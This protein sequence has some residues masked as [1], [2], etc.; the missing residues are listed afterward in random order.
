MSD[1]ERLENS[2]A[3]TLCKLER[4]FP[5]TFFDIM[6]HLSIH[7]ATEAK[8]AGPVQYIW[9]YPFERYL[10]TLKSYVRNKA[11][12]E[13]SIAEGI[14]AQE[15]VTFCSKYLHDVETRLNRVGRNY[16][17]DLTQKSSSLAIF[18]QC[19]LP[20]GNSKTEQLAISDWNRTTMCVLQNCEEVSPY[21]REHI[22][23]IESKYDSDVELRHEEQFL[24]WFQAKIAEMFDNQDKIVSQELLHL[25]R[26]PDKRVDKYTGYLINGF[27]FHTKE[28]E[29]YLKTQNSGVF[30]RGD[31]GLSNKE[32][33]GLVL[34]IIELQYQGSKKIALFKCHWW[35]VYN[36]GRGYKED[37]NGFF[38]VNVDRELAT[39][40]T[41]PYILASQAQQVY[42]GK[43]II[44]PKLLVVVKT[45]PRD[46]YDVPTIER[47][48]NDQEESTSTPIQENENIGDF[49]RIDGDK[50]H[51]DLCTVE[52]ARAN[53]EKIVF[54]L[55]EL[56][57]N[58][59]RNE[60]DLLNCND[61]DNDSFANKT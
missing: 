19:G 23:E 30:V 1:L 16:E 48:A 37:E 25:A 4:I 51:D 47:S 61:D 57:I 44:D 27:R 28:H 34:D 59:E 40:T 13:G 14:I 38:L 8:I 41:D 31:D 49:Y 18:S 43:D 24:G 12:P 46:L 52:L 9:M 3:L 53:V 35:D 6:V 36:C 15:C 55:S 42:Y 11:R 50:D 7:L 10:R 45:Q 56:N 60:D 29:K 21:V 58:V 22:K 26:G 17:G 32:Y 2:I 20:L 33:Y 39:N 54:D 5:P